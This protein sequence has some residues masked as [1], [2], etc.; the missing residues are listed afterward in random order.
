MS[1]LLF[2][3]VFNSVI[4]LLSSEVGFCFKELLINH[5]AYANDLVLMAESDAELQHMLNI[6]NPALAKLGLKINLS[7]TFKKVWIK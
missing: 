7:K 6:L 1:P 4:D 5:L 3:L 2:L